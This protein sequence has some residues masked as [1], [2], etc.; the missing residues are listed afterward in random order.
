MLYISLRNSPPAR[1]AN[2]W[3][4][5]VLVIVVEGDERA[6]PFARRP[7][8]VPAKMRNRTDISPIHANNVIVIQLWDDLSP[9]EEH[10]VVHYLTPTSLC[11]VEESADALGVK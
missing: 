4:H 2:E 5:R 6:D 8:E 9:V 11:R 1:F 10:F 3:I 7:P